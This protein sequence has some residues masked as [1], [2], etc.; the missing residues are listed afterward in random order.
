MNTLDT[1]ADLFDVDSNLLI[2]NDKDFDTMFA[3]TEEED[4]DVKNIEIK[5]NTVQKF[6]KAALYGQS[7]I[8]VHFIKQKDTI[9]RTLHKQELQL[10]QKRVE[11][12]QKEIELNR[13]ELELIELKAKLSTLLHNHTKLN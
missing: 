2:E 6:V 13:R 5:S 1:F 8:W 7:K 4:N 10:E 11:L 12:H 9:T 3:N